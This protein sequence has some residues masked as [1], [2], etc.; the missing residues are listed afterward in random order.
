VDDSNASAIVKGA[1]LKGLRDGASAAAAEAGAGLI[2]SV[3]AA[4][5]LGNLAGGGRATRARPHPERRGVSLP[6]VEPDMTRPGIILPPIVRRVIIWLDR[7]N[8]DPASAA[9]LADRARRRYE[10]EEREVEF[11]RLPPGEDFNSW[12]TKPFVEPGR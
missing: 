10:L 8:K 6:S 9:V 12:L 7:D 1:A 11:R 2:A 5:S 3:W 4:L